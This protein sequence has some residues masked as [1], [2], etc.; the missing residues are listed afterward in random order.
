MEI[1]EDVCSKEIRSYVLNFV[2]CSTFRNQGQPNDASHSC[3]EVNG[4]ILGFKFSHVR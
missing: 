3:G 2:H 4:Q 1:C